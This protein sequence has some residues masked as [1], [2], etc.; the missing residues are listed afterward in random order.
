MQQAG[1]TDIEV[2]DCEV[3]PNVTG[4]VPFCRAIAASGDVRIELTAA[5]PL[6]GDSDPLLI[7]LRVK[8]G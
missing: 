4:P 3:R 7:T 8:S 2:N 6:T 1:W 5:G